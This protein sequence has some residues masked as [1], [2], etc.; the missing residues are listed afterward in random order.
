M[1]EAYLTELGRELRAVGIRGSLRCRVLAEATDH[2]SSDADAPRRFGS[3]REIANAFAAELGTRASR[4]AAVGA[5]AALAV[6]GAVYAVSFVGA[7]FAGVPTADELPILALIA[8]PVIVIAPQIAFVSGL[9]ALVRTL[10]RRERT[11]PSAELTVIN[12]RTTVS[13][14]SGFATMAALAVFALEVRDSVAGWWLAWTLAGAAGAAFLI[15]LAAA[16][17]AKAARFRP[18]IAGEP[19]DLF[20]DLGFGRTDPWRFAR[21]VALG[22]GLVVWLTAAVQGDPIDGAL[23]G[24]AEALACFGGFAVFSRFLGLRR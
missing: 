23:N 2:L 3:P 21:R 12:R 9:L 5:F 1:I 15:V 14:A 7:S 17:A 6:A 16:P 13:L 4:R 20:D 24:T 19:G 18:R 8:F 11:L 22:A 10:R